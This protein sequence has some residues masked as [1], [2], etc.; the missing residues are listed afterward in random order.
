MGIGE[1]I[2][3]AGQDQ[4]NAM[5]HDF[6]NDYIR[7]VEN[8]HDTPELQELARTAEIGPHFLAAQIA[9]LG[10]GSA[11]AVFQ[12]TPQ[13]RAILLTQLQNAMNGGL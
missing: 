9:C 6:G 3:R 13:Q 10:I 4:L 7:A 2:A 5:V 1:K 12:G 8:L 11:L